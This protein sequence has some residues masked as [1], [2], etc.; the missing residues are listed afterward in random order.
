MLCPLHPVLSCFRILLLGFPTRSCSIVVSCPPLFRFLFLLTPSFS[1]Q[2]F[3]MH[4][5][6]MPTTIHQ[7]MHVETRGGYR[8]GRGGG[9]YGDRGGYSDRGAY[10][11]RGGGGS[12]HGGG[13]GGWRTV[14]EPQPGRI[15]RKWDVTNIVQNR[16]EQNLRELETLLMQLPVT[17]H[18]HAHKTQE[19]VLQ[20]P[21]TAD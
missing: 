5:W 11:G 9:G 4:G 6:G 1:S 2:H 10:G 13:R 8:G 14:G 15:L 16:D 7:G 17:I 12:G 18:T 21:C 19:N 3:A 20:L